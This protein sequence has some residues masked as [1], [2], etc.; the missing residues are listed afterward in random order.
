MGIGQFGYVNFV[1]AMNIANFHSAHFAGHRKCSPGLEVSGR[2]TPKKMLV[3]IVIA[4]VVL[5]ALV[6]LAIGLTYRLLKPL[7]WKETSSTLKFSSNA[8]LT[9]EIVFVVLLLVARN[10]GQTLGIWPCQTISPDPQTSK[11]GSSEGKPQ[12]LKI[13]GPKLSM[14]MPLEI[15]K[16]NVVAFHE[17]IDIIDVDIE[18]SPGLTMI[19]LS[20][21]SELVQ[22]ILLAKRQCPIKALGAVNV[23]NRFELLDPESCRK[24]SNGQMKAAMARAELSQTVRP[25][26]RGFEY[27]LIVEILA[28]DEKRPVFR[29]VFTVLEFRKHQY[30]VATSSNTEL[31]FG[32]TERTETL[33]MKMGSKEPSIWAS[34]CKDYNPIHTSWI[35]AKLFGMPGKIAHGN[36]VAAKAIAFHASETADALKSQ[37]IGW[38]EV[39]FRRPVKVPGEL[40]IE[41]TAVTPGGG[42]KVVKDGKVYVDGRYGKS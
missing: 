8:V 3:P 41:A 17:A 11:S 33:S 14:S 13:N 24:L 16:E 32:S 4:S 35:A 34:I 25:K 2:V 12:T 10:I 22:L 29:T 21:V 27:D 9:N 6:E 15:K 39:N 1:E 30:P 36:H 18:N 23:C 28:G 31:S 40:G 42:F 37:D 26:K 19:F 20:A 7:L 38:L 5:L